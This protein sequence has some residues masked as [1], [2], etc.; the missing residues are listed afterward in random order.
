MDENRKSQL[1]ESLDSTLSND[2]IEDKD[3]LFDIA[4]L[5][6]TEIADII[7]AYDKQ[8]VEP[9]SKFTDN[10]YNMLTVSYYFR[11]QKD[12]TKKKVAFTECQEII[13]DYF[14]SAKATSKILNDLFNSNVPDDIKSKVDEHRR[15]IANFTDEFNKIME[16]FKKE[17]KDTM[18]GNVS[19]DKISITKDDINNKTEEL[20]NTDIKSETLKHSHSDIYLI[21]NKNLGVKGF[22]HG[23]HLSKDDINK[24]ILK[25]NPEN[26]EIRVFKLLELAT[27]TET[28]SI[29]KIV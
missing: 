15:F 18:D 12:L 5:M 22:I 24:A 3:A 27:K 1:I 7:D 11:E 23:N 4:T 13:K 29:T 19:E 26:E 2:I 9:Y 8:N 25:H 17:I 10:F 28:I 21:T 6:F 20:S 14:D 16:L